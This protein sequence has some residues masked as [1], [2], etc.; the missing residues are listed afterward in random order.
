MNADRSGLQ[1]L[2]CDI[3]CRI[4]NIMEVGF[5]KPRDFH[6]AR[7][8]VFPTKLLGNVD[9]AVDC[10]RPFVADAGEDHSFIY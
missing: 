2:H 4:G 6:V 9:L 5:C 7:L 8:Q 10:V 3:K 1:P